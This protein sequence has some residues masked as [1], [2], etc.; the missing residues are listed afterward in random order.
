MTFIARIVRS[1]FLIRLRSWEYWPFIILQFPLLVYWIWLAIRARALFFFSASNP[2][3]PTGGMMGESKFDILSRIPEQYIPKS[4]LVKVPVSKGV[5][6]EKIQAKNLKFPLIFKPDLGE[7]GWMVNRIFNEKDLENY[8]QK[9]KT[10]FIVQNLVD[11][12]VELAIYYA[13]FPNSENGKVTSVTM[14]GMLSIKGDGR[15]N[16][17]E[18]IVANDRAKLQW[19]LLSKKFENQLE[20]VLPL[21]E[22]M[23]LVSIGNHCLGTTFLDANNLINE[24]LHHVFDSISKQIDGFYF[25][26]YDLRTA[27]IEDLYNGNIQIM[28]LNGCGAEPAHIYQPGASIF[29]AWK[30][31]FLHWKTMYIISIQNHDQGVPYLKMNE[32]LSIF[33]NFKKIKALH[34]SY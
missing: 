5:L 13:R 8:L 4:L 6:L 10:D 2:S 34:E 14:K 24:K 19:D 31:L 11:L 23:E 15:S 22:T 21:G 18:L 33:R 7:R 20:T 3:I 27:S 12:P 1:N 28:E 25:G 29:A 30:A 32:G 26:R 17:R 16:I 9:I